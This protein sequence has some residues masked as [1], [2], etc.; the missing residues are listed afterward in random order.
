MLLCV[1][2]IRSRAPSSERTLPVRTR[3]NRST[4][5][6]RLRCSSATRRMIS[7]HLCNTMAALGCMLPVQCIALLL[8]NL[9]PL[10]ALLLL[11]LLLPLCLPSLSHELQSRLLTLFAAFG[12]ERCF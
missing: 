2:D 10:L 4:T 6:A 12:D 9:L 5:L 1:L 8:L 11:S 3:I 7:Q